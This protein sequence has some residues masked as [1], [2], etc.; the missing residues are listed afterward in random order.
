MNPDGRADSPPPEPQWSTTTAVFA[1]AQQ[2]RPTLQE[3]SQGPTEVQAQHQR[4]EQELAE[5]RAELTT[6]EELLERVPQI[7]EGKFRERLQPILDENAT[8]RRQLQQRPTNT[9]PSPQPQL[10]PALRT[11]RLRQALRHALGLPSPRPRADRSDD[12]AEAA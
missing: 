4:L 5:V 1:W 3:V 9:D 12:R 7:F 8:L 2:Q 11:P 6:L 10:P